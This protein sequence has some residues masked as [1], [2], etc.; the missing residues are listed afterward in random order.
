MESSFRQNPTADYFLGT[1]SEHAKPA[2]FD[3]D[4]ESLQLEYADQ[5]G[6]DT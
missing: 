4:T 6:I 5:L 1:P 2:Q 3:P